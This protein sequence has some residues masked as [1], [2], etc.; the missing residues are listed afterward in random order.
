[1]DTHRIERYTGFGLVALG[2]LLYLVFGLIR[3]APT[4][5]G[6]YAITVVPIVSGIAL[7]WRT[8]RP[9]ADAR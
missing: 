2:V 9:D 8:S 4:D 5:I 7:I 1:M 6:V 3:G